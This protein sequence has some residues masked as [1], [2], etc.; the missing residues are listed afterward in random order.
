MRKRI[1]LML[2]AC[3]SAGIVV[4][5]PTPANA[6][7]SEES[8]FVNSLNAERASMGRAKLAVKGDLVSVA[9][10]HSARMAEDETIYHNQNLPNEVGGNWYALG[11]N[12][13]MGPTCDSLHDAFMSSAP[14]RANIVDKDYNQIGVGVVIRDNT[15]YVTQVFA[16]R[17]G[18]SPVKR[19]PAA[20]PR[21]APAPVRPR[22]APKPPSAEP[23][24]LPML[25][26]LLGMDASRVNPATGAALGV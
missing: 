19:K 8:C 5:A 14:H 2:V 7:S 17:P 20:N 12:V 9:R 25:L 11:E 23:R 6:L 3:V 18:G 1:T 21:P 4:A 10:R 16:G 22:P 26:F 15:I 24:T 13:G